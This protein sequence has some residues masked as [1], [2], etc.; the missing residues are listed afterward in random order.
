MNLNLLTQLLTKSTGDKLQQK[1]DLLLS[2]EMVNSG[3]F[4][5]L[6]G[7]L[8]SGEKVD[9]EVAGKL[10]DL[11]LASKD[12]K[13]LGRSPAIVAQDFEPSIEIEIPNKEALTQGTPV[14]VDTDLKKAI[15]DILSKNIKAEMPQ[16]ESATKLEMPKVKAEE[17][18]LKQTPKVQTEQVSKEVVNFNEFMAKQSPATQKRMA[19]HSYG[20]HQEKK[21]FEN[22]FD[23]KVEP[24][25]LARPEMAELKVDTTKSEQGFQNQEG[26]EAAPQDIRIPQVTPKMATTQVFDLNKLTDTDAPKVIEQIQNYIIQ[27]RVSGE[28]KVELS[29]HHQDLGKVDLMVEKAGRDALNIR[30]QTQGTE[31]SSFF[32]KNQGDLLQSLSNAGVQVASFKLESASTNSSTAQNFSGSQ[33]DEGSHSSQNGQSPQQ[34]Q[35]QQDSDRRAELWKILQERMAA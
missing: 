28:Q 29:F 13:N 35:R 31:A 25:V 3:E 10:Q 16:E 21:I 30:I 7:E 23:Q 15:N 1:P 4:L 2:E 12:Q 20:N 22:K 26:F 32:A 34:G 8:E 17:A 11:L 27:S 9:S 6:L 14:K 24:M 5:A 19:L 33:Q 18:S